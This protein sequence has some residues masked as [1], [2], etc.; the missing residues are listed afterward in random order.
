M[1]CWPRPSLPAVNHR[2][3]CKV[4]APGCEV[5]SGDGANGP[6]RAD[7]CVL[8]AALRRGWRPG[9]GE[10]GWMEPGRRCF[11][12]GRW[13]PAQVAVNATGIAFDFF[14][15]LQQAGASACV[16]RACACICWCLFRRE[17]TEKKTEAVDDVI[18]KG[19]ASRLGKSKTQEGFKAN[20]DTSA[21]KSKIEPKTPW[22]SN[23]DKDETGINMSQSIRPSCY[24]LQGR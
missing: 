3:C 21:T 12:L 5:T 23:F 22:A 6:S 10:V 24:S 8:A 7:T 19:R 18:N 1:R 13:G 16:C 20:I 2:S 17:E 4:R 9:D 11:C 15:L 14:V